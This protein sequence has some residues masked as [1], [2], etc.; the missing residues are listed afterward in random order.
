[1]IK[2]IKKFIHERRSKNITTKKIKA[3]YANGNTT[4]LIWFYNNSLPYKKNMIARYIGKGGQQ[5][6]FDFLINEMKSINNI[7]LKTILFATTLD[8]LL[9]K[10]IR[11]KPEDS[12]YLKESLNL[13]DNLDSENYKRAD[14][15][16]NEII[17]EIYN[18]DYREAISYFN[19][20]NGFM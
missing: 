10:T 20:K 17:F 3:A 2:R 5:K 8:M 15:M 11:L 18:R 9:D 13:L 12:Q 19:N 14:L 6:E 1:M 16:K 7:Q 4:R